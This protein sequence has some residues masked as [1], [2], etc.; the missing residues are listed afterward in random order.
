MTEYYSN[1]KKYLLKELVSKHRWRDVIKVKTHALHGYENRKDGMCI[2]SF[3][4]NTK[5]KI[6]LLDSN[7]Y[8]TPHVYKLF[9]YYGGQINLSK[10]VINCTYRHYVNMDADVEVYDVEQGNPFRYKKR[11]DKVIISY[12]SNHFGYYNSSTREVKFE[13]LE[14]LY[15]DVVEKEKYPIV[16]VLEDTDREKLYKQMLTDV[17]SEIGKLKSKKSEIMSMWEE[18]DFLNE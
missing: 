10:N 6:K 7:K 4:E 17:D 8:L 5:I 12:L 1:M 15:I 13:T 11:S 3:D 14:Q 2:F 16:K 9:F 18:G